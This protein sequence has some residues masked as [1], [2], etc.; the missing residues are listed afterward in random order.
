MGD[1]LPDWVIVLGAIALVV[2][3]VAFVISEVQAGRKRRRHDHP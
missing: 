3:L 1:V 2:G